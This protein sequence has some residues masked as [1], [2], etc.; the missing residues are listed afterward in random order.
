LSTTPV[1]ASMRR[2][3]PAHD[4]EAALTVIDEIVGALRSEHEIT[5]IGIGAPGFVDDA[6][7]VS[8]APNL[9]WRN[10]EL[11]TAIAR[12]TGLSAVVEKR[13]ER[14]GVG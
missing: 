3:S 7:T 6:S 8:L 13:R 5:A 9:G 10:V 11:G 2:P 1:V 14:R 12:R 4:L